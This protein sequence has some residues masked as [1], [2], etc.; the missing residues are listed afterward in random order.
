MSKKAVTSQEALIYVMV[1]MAAADRKM[2]D[3]ELHRIGDIV[4]KLPAFRNY[5]LDD[6]VA[7]AEACG[8]VLQDEDGL[9]LV[10]DIV[11][12]AIPAKAYDTAYALAVDIAAA[13]LQVEQEELRFLSLL[14]DR[15]SLD[16]LTVAAI[17]RGARARYRQLD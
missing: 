3:R 6:I 16:K 7:T 17:E 1:T 14:A 4:S 15:L 8:E 5:S 2:S 12:D 13:D 10:L 11:A 9:D